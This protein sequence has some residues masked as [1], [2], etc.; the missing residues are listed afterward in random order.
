MAIQTKNTGIVEL[1][2]EKGSP[3]ET[4]SE[5][6]FPPLWYALQDLSEETREIAIQVIRKGAS[7]NTVRSIFLSFLKTSVV[8]IF[9]FQII[10]KYFFL[11]NDFKN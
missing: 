6:G 3:L 9:L 2:L 7:T 1:L 4:Q 8:L 10:A 5:E 11:V